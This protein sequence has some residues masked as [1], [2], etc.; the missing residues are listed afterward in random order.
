MFPPAFPTSHR[1]HIQRA[2]AEAAQEETGDIVNEHYSKERYIDRRAGFLG[3]HKGY[4]HR[5]NGIVDIAATDASTVFDDDF[6]VDLSAQEIRRREIT[7]QI[8]PFTPLM[9]TDILDTVDDYGNL[10]ASEWAPGKKDD[11]RKPSPSPSPAPNM[12]SP[13]QQQDSATATPPLG[14]ASEQTASASGREYLPEILAELERQHPSN[15][16]SADRDANVK[17]P[18]AASASNAE[19]RSANSSSLATASQAPA[20]SRKESAGKTAQDTAAAYVGRASKQ[21]IKFPRGTKRPLTGPNGL[22]ESVSTDSEDEFRSDPVKDDVRQRKKLKTKGKQALSAANA[23]DE[24][25]RKKTTNAKAPLEPE[26]APKPTDAAV[27]A[28]RALPASEA[29]ARRTDKTRFQRLLARHNRDRTAR[30]QAPEDEPDIMPE[31]FYDS[32]FAKGQ[33]QDSVRCVCG[34]VVDDGV[35][36]VFCEQCKVWQHVRCVGEAMPEDAVKGRYLCH[37]C[38]PWAHRRK[39]RDLRAA[40]VLRRGRR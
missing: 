18:V 19:M 13:E 1:S 35:E 12:A 38:D 27:I 17:G 8:V 39:I 33:E 30:G 6:N 24:Q 14:D 21:A 37:N 4:L 25:G 31:Y 23:G 9:T 32:N 26:K 40:N 29:Q 34:T 3:R 2:L 11:R 36:M 20:Q 22:T 15:S 7:H 5:R 28:G 16:S 10:P